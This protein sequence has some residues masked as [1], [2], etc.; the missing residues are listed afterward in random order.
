MSEQ[1]LAEDIEFIDSNGTNITSDFGLFST[2]SF[3]IDESAREERG[4]ATSGKPGAILDGPVENRATITCKPETL[5]V[6]KIMGS[7][8][9]SAGT[10][11]FTENL[12]EHDILRGQFATDNYFEFNDLKIGG[13]TLEANIDEA[14]TINFDPIHAKSGQI[15]QGTVSDYT[16]D[17]NPLNWTDADVKIDGSSF[18]IV[19]SVAGTALDRDI[20]AEHGLGQGR[21]PAEI[22]EGNYSI[23]PSFV[24]KV[25]DAKAWEK[26][27]DD[28]SYPLTVSDSRDTI[29]EISFDFGTG[30]GELVITNAKLEIDTFDMD[31]EK[32]T[33]TI[34]L[35]VFAKDIKVRGL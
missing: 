33:R 11:E 4:V 18:G 1:G 27:L 29:S 13:F 24:I 23:N 35:S 28:S 2:S 10:I 20:N 31:E 17:A 14:V 21:D 6:L 3:I 30:N 32:E 25:E 19:E 5:E 9:S 26:V 15:V 22:I 16:P 8:D 34:E 7:F 12:P